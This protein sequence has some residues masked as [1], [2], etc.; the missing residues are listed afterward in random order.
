MS[1]IG[2]A[3]IELS[4]IERFTMHWSVH[5]VTKPYEAILAVLAT[6]KSVFKPSKATI[7]IIE[8]EMQERVFSHN[9]DKKKHFK[10]LVMGGKVIFAVFEEEDDFS[11]PCFKTIEEAE[12]VVRTPSLLMLPMHESI[13]GEYKLQCC[14][15]IE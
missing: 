11:G 5:K 14:F 13:D 9:H 8:K 10:R 3:F 7:F 15:Q 2:P 12:L 4:K 1:L 6:I